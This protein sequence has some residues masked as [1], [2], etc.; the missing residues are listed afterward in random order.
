LLFLLFLLFAPRE[1]AFTD[2][3]ERNRLTSSYFVGVAMAGVL[4]VV[5]MAG[6]LAGVILYGCA[7][8]INAMVIEDDMSTYG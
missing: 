7:D 3:D 4:A 2:P 8:P 1:P 5:M 6:S